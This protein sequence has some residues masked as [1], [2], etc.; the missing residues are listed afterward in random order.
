LHSELRAAID[1]SLRALAVDLTAVRYLDSA[2]IR[3]L[4]ELARELGLARQVLGLVVPSSSPLRRLLKITRL[5][6]VV[7]VTATEDECIERL[8]DATTHGG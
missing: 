6:E 5:E 8:R 3:A 7:V 4:F 2:G 1:G